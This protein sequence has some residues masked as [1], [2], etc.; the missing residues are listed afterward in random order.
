LDLM[1]EHPLDEIYIAIILREM[2]KALEYLH[3]QRKIHRDIKAANVL[4]SSKGEV[5]L[6]DFGVV[7]Q[8]SDN[9]MKR[10]TFVGTPF[11][12][13][14]EV[15]QQSDYDEKADIWSLGITA[16]EMACGEPPY[17]NVHPMRVL[18]IIPKQKPPRL[19]G[20]FSKQFKHFVE[21]CLQKEPAKRP[22]AK[23]LLKHK[24][25]KNAKR[26]SALIELLERSAEK[27]K[28]DQDDMQIGTL[29]A[30]QTQEEQTAQGDGWD[31]PEAEPTPEEE[32]FDFGENNGG[33]TIRAKSGVN[34][35]FGDDSD[36]EMP[37]EEENKE[38]S[39]VDI[40]STVLD[41][42]VIP[43]IDRIMKEDVNA[44]KPLRDMLN[45]LADLEQAC[46]GMAINIIVESYE[47]IVKCG[48]LPPKVVSGHESGSDDSTEMDE[49]LDKWSNK[50]L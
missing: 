31:F 14:P 41:T 12:M 39:V 20:N 24:F 16:I 17:A 29:K 23:E 18:F 13:A 9:T 6:A 8:L 32:D 22:T 1:D 10:N 49:L 34:Q 46:P 4:L 48:G 19:E 21:I 25:I 38:D 7:G 42:A 3:E 15:I 27:R 30:S 33:G 47:N 43:V 26:V 2:L 5:K 40:E 36:N 50:H 11:W 35:G 37:P 45:A 44:R 28:V